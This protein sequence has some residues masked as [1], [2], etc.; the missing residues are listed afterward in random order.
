MNA[1]NWICLIIAFASLITAVI[2]VIF[3]RQR[4]RRTM[5]SLISML[6]SAITGIFEESV[7]DESMLSSVEA[8]MAQF[9]TSCT[10]S[11]KNLA[12]EK[13]KIK[14]LISDISH[15][16]K[17]PVANIMLYTQLLRE[18]PLP[19]E[20][21]AQ[22]DTLSAQAEKLGFLVDALVK[23]SRLE[24][25][26][27]TL[28][29][30]AGNVSGLI[31]A[32]TSQAMVS[33]RAKGIEIHGGKTSATAYFDSKWTTE[34][35]YNILDNAIK[36]SATDSK[37]SITVS[38]YE[39]FCRIDI[40]D[41]GMGISEDEQSKIFGRFYRSEAAAGQEGVGI[42]LFLAREIIVSGGGY[43]KVSSELSKGSVFSVFL[44]AEKQ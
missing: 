14:E 34:A 26:I 13:D 8:R 25:G 12:N 39:L 3:S 44:P 35:V 5:A 30:A 33:A 21:S 10:V 24:T 2:A 32:V 43:I 31:D 28:N 27:I 38:P 1:F 18:A 23:T 36:Y 4:E 19:P 42:G 22:L 11:S 20:C 9:L 7:F 16:T 17:T 37:I 15:Q 40:A 6:E 29:L 41:Q